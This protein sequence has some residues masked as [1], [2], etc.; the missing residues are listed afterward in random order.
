MKI[1]KLTAE[2]FKVL[3]AVEITPD[4][5]G[6]IVISGPNGAGKTSVLDAVAVLIAGKRFAKDL[7]RP[8]HD[9]A[10][11]GFVEIETDTGLTI[12]RRW[13]QNG[14]PGSLT[15]RDATSNKRSPQAFLDSIIS[16]FAFDPLLF[17]NAKP[18][19]HKAT[20]MPLVELSINIDELNEKKAGRYDDRTIINRETKRLE[21]V[22]SGITKPGA[23]V[24]ES[25]SSL[26][27]LIAEHA[28]ASAA[29]QSHEERKSKA[30]RVQEEAEGLLSEI[31]EKNAMVSDLRSQYKLI[32]KEIT[33]FLPVDIAKMAAAIS[34]VE[35]TNALVR[36]KQQYMSTKDA[37]ALSSAQSEACTNEIKAIDKTMADAL[38]EATFPIDGL[39][40]AEDG[41]TFKGIPFQQCADSEKIKVGISIAMAQNPDFKVILV[42]NASLLDKSN[43]EMI[44]NLTKEKGF[45]AFLEV[46]SDGDG[47][48]IRIEEGEVQTADKEPT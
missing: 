15:I 34:T 12:T 13:T 1:I 3:K 10:E 4:P 48:G 32:D 39:G 23:D 2:N 11:S 43:R 36:S 24:P 30:Q 20:L 17:A 35:E 44:D 6:N 31:Q 26:S 25:E 38:A 45:Q 33:A 21:G 29:L 42:S 9:G 18:S 40:F 7:V 27:D 46:V 5:N 14:T 28:Q 41:I 19:E 47:V 16:N 8:I 37:V 22:L